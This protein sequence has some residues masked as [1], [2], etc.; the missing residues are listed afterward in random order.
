[1]ELCANS[2]NQILSFPQG[3]LL[4]G[5]VFVVLIFIGYLCAEDWPEV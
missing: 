4:F 5:I 3:L 2:R 1:M